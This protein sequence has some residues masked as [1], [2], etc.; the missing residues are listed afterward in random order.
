LRKVLGASRQQLI[1]QFL[2]EA[3]LLAAAAMLLALALAEAVLPF[4]NRFLDTGMTLRW[5]GLDGIAAAG[6]PARPR[7]RRP[8]RS[9]SGLLPFRFQPARVLKA[10]R[11]TA[12]AEGSGHLRNALV[13]G[14][15]AVS[16]GLIICTAVIQ[17]QT[18]YARRSIPAIAATASSRSARS[19]APHSCRGSIPCCARSRRSTESSRPAARRS[20]SIPGAWRT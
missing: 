19:A 20:A 4:V 15:F 18:D 3:I 9:L 11:S 8:W 13:V 5:W 1:A 14:Q 2:G 10:N 16:I 17:A 12:E 6:A 7:R